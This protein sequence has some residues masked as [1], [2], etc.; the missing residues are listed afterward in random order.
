MMG[1]SSIKYSHKKAYFLSF[2]KDHTQLSWVYWFMGLI[3]IVLLSVFG[4]IPFI[5]AESFLPAEWRIPLDPDFPRSGYA[6]N[7]MI[8]VGFVPLFVAP[9]LVYKYWHNLPFKRLVTVHNTFGWSRLWVSLTSVLLIYSVLSLIDFWLN[10]QDFDAV[11]IHQDWRGFGILLAFTL[12]FLPIQAASEEIL[13][14]GYL[15]QGL[16]LITRHPWLACVITSALFAT[17]H[18]GNP[19]ADGQVGPYVFETFILGICMCWLSFEDQ[20]LESAIGFHIGN[21][22]FVFALLGYADPTLPQSSILMTPEPV[23]EWKDAIEAAAY[24]LG[25]TFVIIRINRYL[26]KRAKATA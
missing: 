17:L 16:S 13:C 22:F 5:I 26:T 9:F 25:I 8:W 15:N 6:E 18:L 14:R 2:P 12:I 11:I 1:L 23:I 19:E 21:N 10:P 4:T 3:F 20:G 24:C 7:L